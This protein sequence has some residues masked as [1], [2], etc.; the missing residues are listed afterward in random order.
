MFLFRRSMMIKKRI[1]ALCLVFVFMFNTL[2]AGATYTNNTTEL[3]QNIKTKKCK[4]K[5]PKSSDTKKITSASLKLLNEVIKAEDKDENVFISPTSVMFAFGMANNGARGKT[6]TQLENVINGGIK[7]KS[8]NNILCRYIKKMNKQKDVKWNIANSIWI[9][10]RKDIKVKKRFLKNVKKYHNAQVF[11]A[12]FD[13]NTVKDINKWVKKNTHKMI[14]K[15]MKTIAPDAVTYII[16]AMAF[17]AS[18]AEPFKKSGISKNKDFTNID[19][20]KSKVDMLS[21]GQDYYYTI[22]GANAFKKYYDGY[23][24]AFVGIEMPE[25]VSPTD[26]VNKLAENPDVFTKSLKIKNCKDDCDVTITMPKFELDYSLDIANVIK[27][28]GAPYAFDQNKANL[29]NMFNKKKN[30]NY[31]FSSVIHKTHIEVDKNG[32]KAAAVT[33][34]GTVETSCAPEEK[35]YLHIKLDHPFVYAIVDNKTNVPIFIGTMNKME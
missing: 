27:N 26:Y 23:D 24:Y 33:K 28:M 29:Y 19:G 18:W 15:I 12:A 32:T 10:N 5:K 8:M 11:K 21:E 13:N 31:Y 14:P 7:T 6:R 16:N 30:N 1:I 22:N 25:G 3:T 17:E 4:G 20:S 2:C 34:I 9:R 35:K